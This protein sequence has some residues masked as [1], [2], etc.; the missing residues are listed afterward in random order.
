MGSKDAIHILK[1]YKLELAK[2]LGITA[3]GIFGSVAR[4]EMNDQSD[5]DV[6]IRIAKPDLFLLVDIKEEL[7][8]RFRRPVD[9]VTYRE[10]MNP[11][12]KKKI[13]REAIYA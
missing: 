7:E 4:D 12:L 13:D 6:V 3:I 2:D 1:V 8:T 9:L 11:F 10:N 5:V